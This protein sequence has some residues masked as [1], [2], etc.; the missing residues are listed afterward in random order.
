MKRKN[1]EEKNRSRDWRRRWLRLPR[2]LASLSLRSF[3]LC[4]FAAAS[5]IG[6]IIYKF[7]R[8]KDTMGITNHKWGTIGGNGDLAR[9]PVSVD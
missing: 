6:E 8:H 5:K 7:L 3:A 4:T 2:W 9:G 1:D